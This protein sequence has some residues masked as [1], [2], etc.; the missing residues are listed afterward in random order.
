M[1]EPHRITATEVIKAREIL[2]ETD[3]EFRRLYTKAVEDFQEQMAQAILK[4]MR[5]S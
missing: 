1:K 3:V 2:R 4:E 5:R